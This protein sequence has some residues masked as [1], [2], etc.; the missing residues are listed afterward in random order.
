[1]VPP[2]TDL[3][4]VTKISEKRK[5]TSFS[6]IQL[7]NRRKNMGTEEKLVVISQPEKGERI[8]DICRN[9]RL[10]YSSLCTYNS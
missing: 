10:V 2:S 9:V 3:V 1:V 8:V 4:F 5:S 6:A 7:K